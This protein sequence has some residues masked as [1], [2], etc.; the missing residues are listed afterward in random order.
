M[1]NNNQFN[2]YANPNDYNNQ[3]YPNSHY[4]NYNSNHS[5]YDNENYNNYNNQQNYQY[6]NYNDYNNNNSCENNQQNSYQNNSMNNG[7][8]Q[9]Y[10]QELELSNC[11]ED[12][13]KIRMI[14]PSFNEEEFKKYALDLYYKLQD[15]WTN[16]LQHKTWNN[17]IRQY[18]TD[19]LFNFYSKQLKRLNK[20]N[21]VNVIKKPFIRCNIQ[22]Y[23]ELK[24]Y[25][26]I[27]VSYVGKLIDYIIDLNTNKIVIGDKNESIRINET[28]IFIRTKDM[29]TPETMKSYNCVYCGAGLEQGNNRCPY[30][31]GINVVDNSPN[32]IFCKAVKGI[33]FKY[34]G[35]R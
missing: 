23:K 18:M 19:D 34:R 32:W 28:F 13:S 2:N 6:N 26:M 22:G 24:N 17:S 20:K 8:Q 31:E 14:D 27:V 4:N 29:R 30:C 1:N 9:N 11:L 5:N 3:N 10:G 33:V 16:D 15:A 25:D 21:Q 35:G 12:V 7:T